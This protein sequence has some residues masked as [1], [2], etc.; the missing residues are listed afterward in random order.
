MDPKTGKCSVTSAFRTALSTDL[1]YRG[2][3]LYVEFMNRFASMFVTD[4]RPVQAVRAAAYCIAFLGLWDV[5]VLKTKGLT[6]KLNCLSRQTKK[7]VII[8]C[9]NVILC[10][11]RMRQF[12][13]D[14]QVITKV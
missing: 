4:M 9:N 5:A 2:T 7:D 14:M 1:E 11:K 6:L 12:C 8:A 10:F 13:I 3:W